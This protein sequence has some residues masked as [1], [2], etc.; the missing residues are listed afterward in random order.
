MANNV[1]P[2]KT[3]YYK[4]SHW[5]CTDRKGNVLVYMVERNKKKITNTVNFVYNWMKGTKRN[6]SLFEQFSS[7]TRHHT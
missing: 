4:P 7:K 2:D 3:A 5:F 6:V 1:D